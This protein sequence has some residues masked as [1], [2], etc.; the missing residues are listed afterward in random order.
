[1]IKSYTRGPS[2]SKTLLM[3]ATN[4]MPKATILP[5]S[6][7][8]LVYQVAQA[9]TGQNRVKRHQPVTKVFE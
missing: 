8:S 6:P 5:K 9:K 1:M 7:F 3:G 2:K 4:K